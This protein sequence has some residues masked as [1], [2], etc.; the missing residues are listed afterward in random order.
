M[1]MKA[2]TKDGENPWSKMMPDTSRRVNVETKH[3]FFWIRDIKGRYGLLINFKF[4]LEGIEMVTNVKGISII[5]N[6]LNNSGMLYFLLN[7]QNDWAIFL[8]VCNDLVSAAS[9]CGDESTMTIAISKRLSRWQKFL[10]QNSS[11][12]M[13]EIQQMG[14]FAELY[15]IYNLL[16]P[17]LKCNE[18]ITSWVGPDADKKDFS[19]VDFFLEVKSYISSKGDVVK[20]SSIQQL[21]DEIKPLYLLAV[22]LTKTSQ[23]LSIVDM[24]DSIN[25]LMLEEDFFTK[26]GF[27]TK[28]AAYG[29]IA[30]VTA[31]PFY[32]Y[33]VD[34]AQSYLV[35]S[36]FPRISSVHID[37][38]ILT[39]Q[40]TLEL[41]RCTSFKSELPLKFID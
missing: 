17:H 27:E 6:S 7:N 40:Y 33:S 30:N 1:T 41:A 18:A 20:I 26:E 22:G 13:S 31:P 32:M 9:D 4:S 24:V 3:N 37:P 2:M 21:D 11:T 34:R 28:L 36:D 19:L 10:S 25:K 16:I 12:S 5:M 8:S 15:C 35:S 39:V 14:L 29:F 38:R 23:G